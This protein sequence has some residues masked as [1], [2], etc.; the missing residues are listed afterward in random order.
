MKKLTMT[1][2]GLALAFGIGSSASAAQIESNVAQ[3]LAVTPASKA[4]PAKIELA[5][6]VRSRIRSRFR[7]GNSSRRRFTG[8]P[9][10]RFTGGSGFRNRTANR[11]YNAARRAR[12]Q[13]RI[14]R[15]RRRI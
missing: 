14:N 7:S 2:S 1:L 3:N 9:S 12:L 8:A 10:R 13:R 5:A 15:H 4:A 6:N 11:N